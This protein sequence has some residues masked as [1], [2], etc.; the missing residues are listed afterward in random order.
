[1]TYPIAYIYAQTTH[2]VKGK[3]HGSL[4]KR[5]VAA[6]IGQRVLEKSFQVQVLFPWWQVL[7]TLLAEQLQKQGKH[8]S[9]RKIMCFA[10]SLATK[11]HQLRGFSK[12]NQFCFCFHRN[13]KFELLIGLV[14]SKGSSLSPWAFQPSFPLGLLHVTKF[15]PY[16][17]INNIYP[18]LWGPKDKSKYNST[19]VQCG[20]QKST[21]WSA[22]GRTVGDP[23]AEA[24]ESLHP[25]WMMASL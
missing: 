4:Q 1:M 15:F 25:A 20:E 21:G 11:Y 12:R 5:P 14:S 17:G 6:S 22:I 2:W 3:T 7:Y 9:K 24:L 13:S 8:F 16:E 19:K 23:N 18:S 10:S